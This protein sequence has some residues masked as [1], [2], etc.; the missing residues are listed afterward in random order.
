[1]AL[2]FLFG[3]GKPSFKLAAHQ[4]VE[5]EFE[6]VEGDFQSYF[7]EVLEVAKKRLTLA[8]PGNDMSP[9]HIGTGLPITISYFDVSKNTYFSYRGQVRD[10]R[11]QE[12]DVDIPQA[13]DTTSVEIPP[14]DDSF[15]VDVAIPVK[16]QAHRS[17]HSQV[18]NT[19]AITPHSLYLKTNLAI[20]PET[21]LRV[22]LEVPNAQ[23]IDINARAKGSEKDP[24]DN[25]KHISEVQFEETNPDE[26]DT[27]LSYAVYYQERQK[28]IET[29]GEA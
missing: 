4:T 6:D 27:I 3:K 22:V 25:R 11:D 19:H 26:L 13:K 2:S 24:E 7:V 21:S 20:P 18:A 29:R 12:F 15:R 8:T 10:S 5:I 28:R 17:V 9:V 23:H 16:F 1:M 14:R